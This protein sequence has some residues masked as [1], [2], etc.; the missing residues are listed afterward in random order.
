MNVLDQLHRGFDVGL[1]SVQKGD[2]FG[3]VT[4][5]QIHCVSKAHPLGMGT[6]AWVCG[7]LG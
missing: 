5:M 4:S 1:G 7:Q 2:Q 6:P 3:K